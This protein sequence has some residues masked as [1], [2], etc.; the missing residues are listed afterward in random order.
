VF[1]RGGEEAEAISEAGVP[2]EVIP[3]V[4]SAVAVP[5]Y[6]GIPLTHPDAG[7]AVVLIRGHED[8]VDSIPHLDWHAL[9]AMDGSIVC[10]AGPR[11]VAGILKSL[12]DEGRPIDDAAALIYRGTLPSQRTVTGTIGELLEMVST[13]PPEQDAAG[14]LVIGPVVR[15]REHVRGSTRDRCSAGAS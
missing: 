6:A 15:L 1:G 4:T 7:D 10:W 5:A 8:E 11:L 9:A 14:L 3:G 2:F 12:V 13:A